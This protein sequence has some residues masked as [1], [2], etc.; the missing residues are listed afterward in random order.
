VHKQGNRFQAKIR[1][2]GKD[3]YHGTFGTAKEAAQAYDRAAIQAGRPPS[4]L[5]FLDQVPKS[6][7]PKKSYSSTGFRGVSKIGNRFK[8]AIY[9]G[10]KS[11]YIG[12]FGTA[13][14]A[15]RAYD[16]AALQAKF[17]KSANFPIS[18]LNFPDMIHISE[19]EEEEEQQNECSKFTGVMKE[20][21]L[22][23]AFIIIDDKKVL[24]DTYPRAMF[25]ALAHDRA[26]HQQGRPTTLWNYPAGYASGSEDEGCE[27]AGSWF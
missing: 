14:E 9:I 7:K 2:G 23:R 24:L 1:I 8:A 13:K 4:T 12:M 22:Y 16:Q 5:N 6:Y 10:G 20:G 18:D 21:E 25:A 11:Q 26:A 3:Y 19:E 17:P 27:G 15:A